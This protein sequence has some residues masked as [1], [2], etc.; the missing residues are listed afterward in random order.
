[1]FAHWSINEQSVCNCASVA[2]SFSCQILE[3]FN[4]FI[5]TDDDDD[6]ICFTLWC[7][8]MG[9]PQSEI[10]IASNLED[11]ALGC[12][13]GTHR[14]IIHLYSL[15]FACVHCQTITSSNHVFV[16][17]YAPS[18]WN[19]H[20]NWSS[21]QCLVEEWVNVCISKCLKGRQFALE[22]KREVILNFNDLSR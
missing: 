1:M 16:I 18:G 2:T 15:Q 22:S 10:S 6:D 3:T 4:R 11:S 9:Q 5:S 13:T 17:I 19:G 20:S 7:I 12:W 8:W 21:E 14:A